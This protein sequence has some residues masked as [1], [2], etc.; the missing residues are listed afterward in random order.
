[1]PLPAAAPGPV[2][3]FAFIAL[4]RDRP[5]SGRDWQ[6]IATQVRCTSCLAVS[7]YDAR[8]VGRM[9]DA[10]GAP[11]LVPCDA[12]GAPVNPGA[13]LPFRMSPEDAREAVLQ[14]IKGQGVLRRRRQAASFETV[15]A[16]YLPCWTFSAHYH[17]AWRGEAEIRDGDDR[18]RVAIDGV[19]EL[20]FADVAIPASTTVPAEM[21]EKAQPFPLSE[22]LP[23]DPRY[24]AGFTV[25]TY[26]VNMWDAWDAAL[27]K[28]EQ[29]ADRALKK[30]ARK[31]VA[32]LESWPKWTAEHCKHVL[33]P[34]YRA[35]Y[36]H[37]GA[38]YEVVVNG[39]T[40]KVDG[41]RPWDPIVDTLGAVLIIAVPIGIIA[42]LFWLVRAVLG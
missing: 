2:D 26:A 34:L 35:T 11:A 8:I 36:R 41:T 37:R 3:G 29:D 30:D 25:E 10:C 7:T 22:L 6:P 16:L 12:T 21:W 24:L 38:S 40:V 4:L 15:S 31:N 42:A 17:C 39:Y 32:A 13:V 28:M 33:V 23:F 18:R 1:M 19:V 27:T 5:D 9:C 14:W 20:D